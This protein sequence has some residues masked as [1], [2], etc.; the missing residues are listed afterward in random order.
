MRHP[1]YGVL[2]S[3]LL[4]APAA[5]QTAGTVSKAATGTPQDQPAKAAS[6]NANDQGK[7]KA[8]SDPA[9]SEPAK[10]DPMANYNVLGNA[11]GDGLGVPR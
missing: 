6:Q 2:I 10:D 8:A 9:P 11:V 1:I 3:L 4:A 7:A 5:A